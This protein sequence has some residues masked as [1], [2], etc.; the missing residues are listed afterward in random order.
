MRKNFYL[1]RILWRI[2]PLAVSAA[3]LD[4]MLSYSFGSFYTLMFFRILIDGLQG[5]LNLRGILLFLVLFAAMDGA[6]GAFTAWVQD[7]LLPTKQP[8]LLRALHDMLLKKAMGG[9][10]RGYDDPEYY[11]RLSRVLKDADRQAMALIR[12]VGQLVGVV[13]ALLLNAGYALL[14]ESGVLLI[15]IPAGA[16][17]ILLQKRQAQAREEMDRAVTPF[18]R[19][20]QAVKRYFYSREC[21]KELRMSRM[22]RVLMRDYEGALQAQDRVVKRLSPAVGRARFGAEFVSEALL[23]IALNAWISFRYLSGSAWGLSEYSA[24]SG[25]AVNLSHFMDSLSE[26][27]K[28]LQ[29]TAIY[30]ERV[31]RFME[32]NYEMISGECVPEFE[33]T[34]ELDHVRFG[35]GDKEALRGVSLSIQKGERIALVGHNGA[36]KSTLIKLLMRLYDPDQGQVKLDGRDVRDMKLEAYRSLFCCAFQDFQIYAASLA[37]NVLLRPLMGGQDERKVERALEQAGLMEAVRAMPRGIHSIMTREFDENGVQL[38]GGQAQALAIAR[39]FASDAPIA[40]LDEPSA[41]L[42]PIK[43]HQVFVQLSQACQDKTMILI[44]HRLSTTRDC[45]RIYLLERGKVAE[46]GTH[47]E[48]MSRDGRYRQMFELQAR[49]YGEGERHEGA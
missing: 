13:W 22:G 39:I 4:R 1:Y 48:L 3:A 37:E 32:S 40:I 6:K 34:L 41:A 15:C 7:I 24:L 5:A 49:A 10:M 31:K 17:M 19:R 47:H 21:A 12:S 43:E 16:A 42:D 33:S 11:D 44:S 23:F 9:G 8:E 27:V 45:D 29:Q 26:C 20:E 35:Y 28:E 46:S 30:S 2:S 38:S 14:K 25:A 18:V 36:G